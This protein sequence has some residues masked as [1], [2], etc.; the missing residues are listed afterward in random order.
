MLATVLGVVIGIARLSRIWIVSA[1]A[2]AYV[3]ALRNTPLLLQ[4]LFWY[5]LSQ[6]LPGPR[7][8]LAPL[9]GVFLCFAAC[10]FRAGVA[11]RSGGLAR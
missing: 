5:S 11:R 2:K 10:F 7:D 9:P 8:A 6:T 3:E 4:L 1:M